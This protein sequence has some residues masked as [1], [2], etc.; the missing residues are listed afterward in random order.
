MGSIIKNKEF[1]A[2]EITAFALKHFTDKGYCVWRQ[3]NHSTR[4]RAFTGMKGVSDIIGWKTEEHLN[5]TNRPLGDGRFSGTID[6]RIFNKAIWVACEVK[7]Q[8]DVFK[9]EQRKFLQALKEA[10]GLSFF[11]TQILN[12]IKIIEY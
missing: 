12:E 6:V 2:G 9:P 7:K 11:A 4:G 8:G 1:S 3:N 5:G 10:G